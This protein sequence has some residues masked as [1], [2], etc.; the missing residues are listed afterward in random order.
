V[1]VLHNHHFLKC[2]YAALFEEELLFEAM[3]DE[4]LVLI[5]IGREEEPIERREARRE[6]NLENKKKLW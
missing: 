3:Q 4:D 1:V 6:G 2:R 5:P